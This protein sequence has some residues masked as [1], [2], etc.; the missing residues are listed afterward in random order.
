MTTIQRKIQDKFEHYDLKLSLPL[1]LILRK[2]INIL[3]IKKKKFLTLLNFVSRDTVVTQ[4][5]VRRPSVNSGFTETTTRMD[6][7]NFCG[8]LHIH[9]NFKTY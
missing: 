4:A 2:Q 6:P 7:A 3:K 9:H 8:N 5:S 1:G